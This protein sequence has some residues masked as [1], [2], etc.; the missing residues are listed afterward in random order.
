[1]TAPKA[2]LGF[3]KLNVP[4]MAAALDFWQRGFG[5]TVAQSFDEADFI[6]HIMALPDQPA[7]P[8]LLLVCYKDGRAITVGNG[9]GPVGLACPDIAASH[10]HALDCG[11]VA[12]TGVFDVGPVKVAMLHSPQ[13]HEIELVQLPG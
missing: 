8:N 3:F 11:A 7:G 2:T 6:E 9:H 13:G 1:M 5:F 10:A 12:L 4:D